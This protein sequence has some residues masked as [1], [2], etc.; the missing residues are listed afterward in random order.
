MS[1]HFSRIGDA[2]KTRKA[3]RLSAKSF[4]E[5]GSHPPVNTHGLP[6]RTYVLVLARA[7]LYLAENGFIHMA[8]EGYKLVV[9]C[10]EAANA[11]A[12]GREETSSTAPFIRNVVRRAEAATLLFQSNA[13]ASASETE[14]ESKSKRDRNRN[15][16][17]ATH[18]ATGE[19]NR[20]RSLR[21][22]GL[23]C[24]YLDISIL[25]YWCTVG[26]LFHVECCIRLTALVLLYHTL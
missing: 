26:I 24:L 14:T 5:S 25:V 4:V 13:S 7:V 11:L 6:R 8:E 10:E 2:L 15:V 18:A 12:A 16:R 17:N 1:I 19:S 20:S 21:C 23:I 9:Q 3:L 22:K